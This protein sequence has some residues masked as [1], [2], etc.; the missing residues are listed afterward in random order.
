MACL[1]HE[2][3]HNALYL[4]FNASG[5][6]AAAFDLPHPPNGARWHLAVDTRRD[7][8]H[9]L[10]VADQEPLLGDSPAYHVGPRSSVILVARPPTYRDN[11]SR[12]RA[13]Y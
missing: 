13:R 5:E 6:K 3:E 10:C 9:D 2:R 8:P 1:I 4:M 12:T 11:D 7:A